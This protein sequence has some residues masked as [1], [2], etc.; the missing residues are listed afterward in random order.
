MRVAQYLIEPD[1]KAVPL[2][3]VTYSPKASVENPQRGDV[4]L[5]RGRPDCFGGTSAVFMRSSIFIHLGGL[6]PD[7]LQCVNKDCPKYIM[8]FYSG[9]ASSQLHFSPP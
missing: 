2:G 9:F 3:T 6:I 8:F 7:F 4:L 1:G 5:F